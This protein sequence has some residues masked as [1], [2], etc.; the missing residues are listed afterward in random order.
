MDK[1]LPNQETFNWISKVTEEFYELVY[2]DPWFKNIFAKVEQKVITSQQIDF[3]IQALGGPKNFCGR[4]PNDAHP[5]IWVDENIWNYREEL[6]N[7]A[8]QNVKAPAAI[9]EKWLKID[10]AFKSNILNKAGPEEC[11]GRYKT[12]ETIYFPMPDHLKKKAA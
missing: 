11:Y 6:L 1:V 10:E 3:M 12:E 8:F 7:Q 2:Q 9:Q 4:S 5:H